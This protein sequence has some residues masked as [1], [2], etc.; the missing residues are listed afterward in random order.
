M[1][2]SVLSPIPGMKSLN[3]LPHRHGCER[4]QKIVCGSKNPAALPTVDISLQP[5]IV[6][7]FI[8]IERQIDGAVVNDDVAEGIVSHGPANRGFISLP[9][10]AITGDIRA[11]LK[12]GTVGGQLLRQREVEEDTRAAEVIYYTLPVSAFAG[13]SL[14][15]DANRSD[16]CPVHGISF[17]GSF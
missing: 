4:S 7:H 14:L 8:R 3:F 1:G 2:E 9:D 5:Q 10:A 6:D 11:K 12:I 17:C 16:L 13:S 15:H